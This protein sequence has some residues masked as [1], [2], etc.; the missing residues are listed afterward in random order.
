MTS[1]NN[2]KAQ[3]QPFIS[4]VENNLYLGSWHSSNPEILKDNNIDLIIHIGYQPDDKV[5]NVIYHYLDVDDNSQSA[6]HYFTTICPETI[7]IIKKTIANDKR[8]LVSCSA[9][10]SRSVSMIL[11]YLLTERKEKFTNFTQAYEYLK[12]RRSVIN[13]NPGFRYFLEKKL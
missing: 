11:Y 13:P 4:N 10:K 7:K 6:N 1:N 2:I 3:H 8:V 9:G 12:S 5:D